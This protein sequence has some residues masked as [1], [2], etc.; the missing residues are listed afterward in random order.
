MPDNIKARYI[1]WIHE[2]SLQP[3]SLYVTQIKA[4][5]I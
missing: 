2:N 5:E 3:M 4:A 1:C